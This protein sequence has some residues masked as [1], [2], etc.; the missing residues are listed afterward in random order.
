MCNRHVRRHN[1]Q[2]AR[3]V[4]AL[5][6]MKLNTFLLT[7]LILFSVVFAPA[8]TIFRGFQNVGHGLYWE[9]YDPAKNNTLGNVTVDAWVKIDPLTQ[10]GYIVSAGYGGAHAVLFGVQRIND[11]YQ[12]TGNFHSLLNGQFTNYSFASNPTLMTNKWYQLSV[13]VNGTI[14]TTYIDGV[15]QTRSPF[16]GQRV[17][18]PVQGD[19]YGGLLYIAGSDHLNFIGSIGQ[20]RIVEGNAIYGGTGFD[21]QV[22]LYLSNQSRTTGLSTEATFLAD[23]AKCGSVVTDESNGYRGKRFPGAYTTQ[24]L[25]YPQCVRDP[26]Y[27]LFRDGSYTEP[28]GEGPA[29]PPAGAT[30]FDSF[31]RADTLEAKALGSTDV[32]NQVWQHQYPFVIQAG[33]AAYTGG[34]YYATA[35][36]N[37][38]SNG[39][40][41]VDRVGQAETGLVFRAAANGL[42][43]AFT[44]GNQIVVF[45]WNTANGTLATYSASTG[46]WGKLTVTMNGP[47]I[48]VSTGAGSLDLTDTEFSSNTGIGI[49][50]FSPADIYKFEN[51]T[52]IPQ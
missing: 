27:P 50:T 17:A 46:A 12:I 35:T 38:G 7:L 44:Q 25:P 20:V 40:L 52:F 16:A 3:I 45:K 42:Y 9:G 10:T 36:V 21:R 28:T 24:T 37:G 15:P 34:N 19:P 47:N 5:T 51:F 11:K 22:S 6:A 1:G 43:Q 29:T 8:Q 18:A 30:V 26:S 33:S 49:S 2:V 13:E 4:T 48:N 14:I 31:N 32:G 39:T 23:Y 41:S